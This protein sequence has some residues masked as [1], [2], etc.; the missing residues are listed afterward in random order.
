MT[1]T[2]SSQAK[3]RILFTVFVLCISLVLLSCS[4]KHWIKATNVECRVYD[5]EPAD[6][7]T[8]TWEGPCVDGYAS[9]YG[10]LSVYENGKLFVKCKGHFSRGR[11][12]DFIQF[13][14]YKN[15]KF[16]STYEEEWYKG[17]PVKRI[18]N[19]TLE[20]LLEKTGNA[21]EYLYI[22]KKFVNDNPD[23]WLDNFHKV[24]SGRTMFA[25][26]D[27]T[28]KN[29]N[30]LSVGKIFKDE[31]LLETHND[32]ETGLSYYTVYNHRVASLKSLISDRY[33]PGGKQFCTDQ[34]FSG[35]E[36]NTVPEKLPDSYAPVNEHSKS[37]LTFLKTA[38][39]GKEYWY[40]VK[41]Y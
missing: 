7:Q 39:F 40:P 9:G 30:G 23:A 4:M 31:L 20:K 16:I 3:Q 6:G 11:I 12:H 1:E 15:D 28:V 5:P 10:T 36:D 21:R 13:S 25:C 32:K 18:R 37:G 22:L 19:L 14:V 26:R 41:R 17:R 2:Q 33:Y 29:K 35:C 34:D 8:M 24:L 38:N 27:M